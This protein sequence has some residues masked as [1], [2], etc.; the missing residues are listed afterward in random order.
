MTGK[1]LRGSFECTQGT[2][3]ASREAA[4]AKGSK[5]MGEYAALSLCPHALKVM[6]SRLSD[7]E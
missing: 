3:E 2:T 1:A 7:C 5:V 6:A 4:A